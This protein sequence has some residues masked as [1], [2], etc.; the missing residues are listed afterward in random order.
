MTTAQTVIAVA[1][2]VFVIAS[3]VYMSYKFRKIMRHLSEEPDRD[4]YIEHVR[5][6]RRMPGVQPGVAVSI[7]DPETGDFYY[8]PRGSETRM[9][10]DPATRQLNIDM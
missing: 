8:Y 3:T 7:Q 9:K 6:M 1:L 4:P 10:R 2:V 5:L